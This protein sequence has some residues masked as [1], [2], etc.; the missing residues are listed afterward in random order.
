M[1]IIISKDCKY[2]NKMLFAGD[3]I[4]PVKD[5]LKMIVALNE[6]GYINPLSLKEIN[7]I[8]KQKKALK[9]KED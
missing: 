8:S 5:N 4:E 1:K 6:K 9:D 3:E 2:N 7:E